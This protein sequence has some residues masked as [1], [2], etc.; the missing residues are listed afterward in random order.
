MESAKQGARAL[1]DD[2]VQSNAALIKDSS[3]APDGPSGEFKGKGFSGKW[4][5]DDRRIGISISLSLMLRAIK[6]K[7]LEKLREKM[8]R[9]FPDG[10]EI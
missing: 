4:F 10:H 2:F 7:V 8:Q 3:V 1:I 5:V 6:G 9:S